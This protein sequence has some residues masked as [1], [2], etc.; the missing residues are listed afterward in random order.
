VDRT[1][2]KA[3]RAEGVEIIGRHLLLAVRELGGKLTKRVVSR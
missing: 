2:V 3:M 1:I